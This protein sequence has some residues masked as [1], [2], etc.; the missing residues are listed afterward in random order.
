MRVLEEKRKQRETSASHTVVVCGRCMR[1]FQADATGEA[2]HDSP[3]TP[4]SVA[5][6]PQSY[7]TDID[8]RLG[9]LSIGGDEAMVVGGPFVWTPSATTQNIRSHYADDISK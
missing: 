2:H 6:T 3:H 1:T 5:R 9:N 4:T 8:D 7:H